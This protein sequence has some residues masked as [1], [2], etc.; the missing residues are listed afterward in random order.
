MPLSAL[1]FG[2][3]FGYSLIHSRIISRG[4]YGRTREIIL[5]LPAELVEKIYRTILGNFGVVH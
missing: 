1:A 3:Y 2:W 4:R 5:D